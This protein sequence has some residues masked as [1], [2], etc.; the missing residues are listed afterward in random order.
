MTTS[1][2]RAKRKVRIG[3]VTSAK[4]MKTVTVTLTRLIRHPLYG[5]VLKRKK[6]ILV[7]DEKKQCKVGDRVRIME[8]RPLSS[9]KRW[10]L[11]EVLSGSHGETVKTGSAS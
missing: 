4:M 2:P 9:R 8:T 5:K 10:R 6:K 1:S 3:V 11:V 7:H